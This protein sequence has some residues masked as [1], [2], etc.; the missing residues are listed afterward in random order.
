MQIQSVIFVDLAVMSIKCSLNSCRHT[1]QAGQR[2]GE[3][4]HPLAQFPKLLVSAGELLAHPLYAV[5]K[6][7]PLHFVISHIQNSLKA[8]R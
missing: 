3:R 2:A 1:L 4:A 8:A 7:G 6:I 5:I